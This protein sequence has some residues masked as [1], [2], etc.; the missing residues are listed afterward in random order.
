MWSKPQRDSSPCSESEARR[1]PQ[2]PPTAE[3]RQRRKSELT[4]VCSG[5]VRGCLAR[6]RRSTCAGSAGAVSASGRRPHLVPA[7]EQFDIRLAIDPD[8]TDPGG[9]GIDGS[10]PPPQRRDTDPERLGHVRYCQVPSLPQLE[11]Q[12]VATAVVV[13]VDEPRH[14]VAVVPSLKV[15]GGASLQLSV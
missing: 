8:P 14:T 1:S 15:D 10:L 5:R 7:S 3:S 12:P 2:P 6:G 13:A 9:A 11:H 4:T